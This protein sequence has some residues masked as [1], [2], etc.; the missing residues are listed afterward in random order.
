MNNMDME[1]MK[2]M[3]IIIDK[4][5]KKPFFIDKIGDP[6]FPN[7]QIKWGTLKTGDYSINGMSTADALFS[8]SIERKSLTDLFSSMGR[9]RERLQAEFW[10][11]SEFTYSALIIENDFR[12]I[13]QT[14]PPES[15]MRPKAV[16]RSILAFSQR[17]NLHC[18]PCPNR[19]FA[20][21]T[22]FLILKRFWD[23]YVSG[24]IGGQN[25]K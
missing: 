18:F 23:D 15:S 9:G 1:N 11:M 3:E 21:K 12:A 19:Q 25:G 8:I 24:E 4:R 14:P 6:N 13:F 16:Y 5:E 2:K 10:R 22:T 7:L 20:E 17:Y